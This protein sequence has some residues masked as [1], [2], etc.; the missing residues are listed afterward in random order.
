LDYY[1][2][3]AFELVSPKLGAQ[4]AIIGGGRYDYMVEEFGGPELCGIG[5]AVGMERLVSVVPFKA[6]K[7]K[8]LY[9]AYLGEE[10]KKAGME[11]TRFLRS[12]GVE[13]LIEYKDRGLKSNLSRANKLKARWVVMIG[14]DEL[15]SGMYKLKD[16]ETG[17]Q[18]DM[19]RD[20]ILKLIIK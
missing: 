18:Q 15:K 11:L 4:N 10:A 8:F 13:C 2:K 20:D 12:K 19:T 6:E 14:E 5:F 1:T 16:M 9:L 17:D 7:E 3:T